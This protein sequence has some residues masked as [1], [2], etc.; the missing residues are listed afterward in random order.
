MKIPTTMLLLCLLAFMLPAQ[1]ASPPPAPDFSITT[2]DGVRRNLYNDYLAQGKTVVLYLFF[3]TCPLCATIS[4]L[5][6]PFYQEW[7]GA[8]GPVDFL[9]LSIRTTDNNNSV[10]RYRGEYEFSFQG[11]GSDGGALDAIRP[12]TNGTYGPFVGTPMF[13]VIAPDSSVIYDPRGNNNE[14]TIDS[15]DQAI[16]RTGA[17]KPMKNFRLQGSVENPL[18]QPLSDV[19]ITIQQTAITGIQTDTSGKF[20]VEAPLVTRNIYGARFARSDSPKNGVSTYDVVR[21]QRHLLGIE[22]FE[23]PYELIAADVDRNGS[24]NI[25]DVVHVRKLVLSLESELP[26]GRSWM[27]LDGNYVFENPKEPFAEAYAGAAA[28]FPFTAKGELP[29]FRIIAI[30][31]GDI[32]FNAR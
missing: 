5:M 11:A 4:P 13:I 17:I 23:S 3:T 10:R 8:D 6:E 21:I 16:R 25:A 2:T 24:I 32:D 9:L 14:A 30:K 22:P 29:P 19:R 20:D 18:G 12:Y 1:N 27:F 28:R 31:I 26:G 7:G 15:L